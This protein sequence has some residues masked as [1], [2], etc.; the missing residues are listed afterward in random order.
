WGK[1]EY[2]RL[3]TIEDSQDGY[4]KSPGYP[5]NYQNNANYTWIIKTGY[6]AN[7]YFIIFFMDIKS[8]QTNQCNDYLQITEIDPC[9]HT[10]LKRCGQFDNIS[11]LTRGNKIRVSFVSD[12]SETGKGFLL[13]WNVSFIS[14]R[15]HVTATSKKQ[16]ITL[17]QGTTTDAETSM[18]TTSTESETTREASTTV[19]LTLQTTTERKNHRNF[20]V[21]IFV[22]SG[23]IMVG[24]LFGLGCLTKC[25]LRRTV[26]I[27]SNEDRMSSNENDFNPVPIYSSAKEAKTVLY[28]DT[29]DGIYMEYPEGVYDTTFVRRPYAKLSNTN[30]YSTCKDQ[31]Q[32]KSE[33]MS[34]D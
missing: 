29:Q 9:C 21:N 30:I 7:F 26:P 20:L 24:L 15:S 23:I 4:I 8:S 34:N 3:E 13:F 11:I 32:S 31:L 2:T 17:Q 10:P 25:W 12:R 14:S 1:F 5:V 27:M 18:T 6:V 22:V 16:I 33:E 19:S 28:E